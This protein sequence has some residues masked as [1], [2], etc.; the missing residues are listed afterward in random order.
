MR[1]RGPGR[2]NDVCPQVTL[3]ALRL[4]SRMDA[5]DRPDGL[6]LAAT[7]MLDVWRRR[8]EEHPYSFGHGIRFK[9]VKWPPLW[10]GIYWMLDTFGRYP[11]LWGS[12]RA[13]DRR[14]VAELVACLVS[15]NVSPDGTVTPRS[16]YRGFGGFSFGEKRTPSPIATALLA[17][18]AHRFAELAHDVA[19][20]EVERLASSK[21]G[22]GTPHPPRGNPGRGA[23]PPA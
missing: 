7:T 1:W 17:V 18:V 22:T 3:E 6:E 8:G 10:F 20:V 21:G 19:N 9:T 2:K 4:F 14:A 23:H 13:E 15:Y 12:E 5:S 16:V 11:Q